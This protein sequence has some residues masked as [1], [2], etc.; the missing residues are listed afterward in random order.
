MTR[1]YLLLALLLAT[2]P[3]LAAPARA[4]PAACAVPDDLALSGLALPAARA[5]VRHDHHLTILAAGSAPTA[6]AAAHGVA[7]TYP[8]RLQTRLEALL[9]GITV[10]VINAGAAGATTHHMLRRLGA[11]IG[12]AKANLL[13][14]ETGGLEAARGSDVDAFAAALRDGIDRARAAGAD[15][16]LLDLQYAPS[17]VRVVDAA[18]YRRALEGEAVSADVPMLRRYELMQAWSEAGALDFDVTTGQARIA[19]ARRLYDCLA[20]ALAPAIAAAVK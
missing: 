13:L 7:F 15:V 10:S 6:G 1:R 2:L 5:A 20:A 3:G 14:W 17:I 19:V 12:E 8:A 11:D 9:P 4:E 16:I 18:P